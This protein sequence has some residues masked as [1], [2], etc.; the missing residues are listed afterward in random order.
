M[1]PVVHVSMASSNLPARRYSSARAAKAIDAGSDWTR[2]F[3]SSM[4]GLSATGEGYCTCTVLVTRPTLPVLSVTVR[5]T[6]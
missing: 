5:V 1:R 3:N 2:R 4:R 6:L